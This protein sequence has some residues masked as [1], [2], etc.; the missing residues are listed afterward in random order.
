MDWK[1]CD[2]QIILSLGRYHQWKAE[3]KEE[4]KS[5]D[6]PESVGPSGQK[7]IQSIQYTYREYACT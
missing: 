5:T 3:D 2:G 4:S 6:P 1:I 7:W